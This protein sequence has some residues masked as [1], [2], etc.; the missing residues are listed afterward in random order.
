MSMLSGCI[1]SKP[2]HLKL[3]LA[4]YPSNP[5]AAAPEFKPNPQELSKLSYYA[6][7]RAGKL[8]KL[9]DVFEKRA[10]DEARRAGGGNPKSR[11]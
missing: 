7:N 5:L 4:C 3:V 1:P 2:N 6:N 10:T 8:A 9:A 11:A